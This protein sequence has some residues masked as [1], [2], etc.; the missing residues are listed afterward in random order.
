MTL[1]NNILHIKVNWRFFCK[2]I[3]D[4]MVDRYES[5][6][7]TL[8]NIAKRWLYQKGNKRRNVERGEYHQKLLY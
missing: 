8:A 5:A 7:K 3:S 2:K 6:L 1:L 4:P